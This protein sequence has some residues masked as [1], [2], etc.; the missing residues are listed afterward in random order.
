MKLVRNSH[1]FSPGWGDFEG[2]ARFLGGE[3]GGG[4][5]LSLVL[6][7]PGGNVEN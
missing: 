7:F 4:G 1:Y 6:K 2:I 5:S 3:R